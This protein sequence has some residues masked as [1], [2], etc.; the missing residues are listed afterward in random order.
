MIPFVLGVAGGT[1]SGKTTAAY[2]VAERLGPD[3]CALLSHDHYYLPP[4]PDIDAVLHNF[5]EPAAL[6]TSL[7]VQHLDALRR[8]EAVE[9]PRYDFH[10]HRRMPGFVLEPRPILI[11]EG[12]LV[13]CDAEL[14]AR[15]D[16]TIFFD[17]PEFVRLH[18]RLLRDERERGRPMELTLEQY[19]STVRPMHE[20][21]V[22]PCRQWADLVLDGRAELARLRDAM[23]AMVP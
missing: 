14:R 20:L 4:P 21:H 12:I 7:L 10:H 5:D 17:T 13:L 6:E 9:V 18:R 8:G 11:V 15:F 3:Q 23:L 1:A 19:F 2:A 22:A 16:R